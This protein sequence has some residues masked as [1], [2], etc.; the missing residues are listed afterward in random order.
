V[1]GTSII[2]GLMKRT[3]KAKNLARPVTIT[4]ANGTVLDIPKECCTRTGLFRKDVAKAI[5]L[6]D[7]KKLANQYGVRITK[8]QVA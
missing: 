4:Y 7:Y 6:K 2:D 5:M 3:Y 1:K 8:K